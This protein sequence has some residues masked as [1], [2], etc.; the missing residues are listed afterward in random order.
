MYVFNSKMIGDKQIPQ[1]FQ[2]V[3][4]N[5]LQKMA[6]QVKQGVSLLID[7][8]WASGGFLGGSP[9]VSI[10]YGR[11]FDGSLQNEPD[12]ELALY[13]DHYIVKDR[14]FSGINTNDIIDSIDDGTMFDTSVGYGVTKSI[15]SIDGLDYFGGQCPHFRGEN[16]DGQ[17][18]VVN[19]DDGY[20][21]ENSLVFDGAYPG[22][23]VV[24]ASQTAITNKESPEGIM[25]LTEDEAVLKNADRVLFTFSQKR[26]LQT[27]AQVAKSAVSSEP[28]GVD[29]VDE[30]QKAQQQLATA[31]ASLSGVNGILAKVREALGVTSDEAIHGAVTSL[32]TQA[33]I[34]THYATKVVDEACSAGVRAMGEA[35]NVESMKTAFSH[36]SVSEVEKIRDSYQAQA[37]TALGGGGQHL[38]TEPKTL[39]DNPSANPN[40]TVE[41]SADQKREQAAADAKAVLKRTGNAHLMK[42]AN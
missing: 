12:G 4:P 18:C 39:P 1:R 22:A 42:E 19:Q 6:Q 32:K 38:A 7:H 13:A 31:N 2:R 26:G 29:S 35:F 9:R 24:A 27:Y 37:K 8:P 28:K 40:A 21:M 23:G 5:F 3:T 15:C 14:S 30:L 10:P 25:V 33:E 34:G 20:L 36:L 16:Y 11:T 17:V 41:L